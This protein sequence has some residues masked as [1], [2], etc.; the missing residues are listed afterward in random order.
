[1]PTPRPFPPGFRWGAATAA[2]QIE[3]AWNEGGR[4]P[5]IWDTFSRTPGAVRDGD[6]GDVACDHYHRYRDDIA[7]LGEL[8]LSS[9]RLSVSWS[10]LLDEH[11]RPNPE[12][13]DFYRRLCGELRD[14]GIEPVVT[15]YH[16]DLPQSIEDRGGWVSRDTA[17]RF[18]E[19]AVAAHDALGA[20]VDEWIT[21]NEPW[22]SSHLGYGTGA[23]APG[24]R[25]HDAAYAATAHLLLAHGL[26][27][28]ALRERSA[29][30]RIG[31]ALNLAPIVPASAGPRR[32]WRWRR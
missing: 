11:Q 14:A 22:V 1:M 24:I 18:A 9:Y 23:H 25:D 2:Y 31:V 12:G 8:G 13:V 20:D 10:R 27:L 32:M 21:L 15:L 7:L 19:Y 29:S 17:T 3:G 26:G 30:A 6:T 5:S 16:W 4:R 28:A